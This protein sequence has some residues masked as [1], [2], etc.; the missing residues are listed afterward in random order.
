MIPHPSTLVI[1][2]ENALAIV[3]GAAGCL[4]A[5]VLA[6]VM[7]RAAGRLSHDSVWWRPHF[8]GATLAQFLYVAAQAGIFSFLINYMTSE[9]PS[10]PASWLNENTRQWVELRT[11]F[12][13]SDF[14]D[15]PS[16]AGKLSD[17]ADPVSGFLA[18]TLSDRTRRALARYEEGSA[19]PATLRV[20]LMQDL[21]SL[22][23]KQ[24]I[25]SP[26]RFDRIAL[27]DETRRCWRRTRPNATRR[28]STGCCSP[29]PIRR[30]CRSATGSSRS[31][32]RR[33]PTWRR[34]ASSASC[35]AG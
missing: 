7:G 2:A 21:N 17:G 9:P 33:R 32:T 1:T 5:A 31:P 16:L 35:S 15:M 27:Q 20:A 3:L 8:S 12:A 24:G 34:S 4:A 11:A 13:G 28:G 23:Q 10:L 29:M 18:S 30:S 22:I 14:K 19:S 25:Y 6:V 26:E